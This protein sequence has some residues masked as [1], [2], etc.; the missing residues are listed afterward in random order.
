MLPDRLQ[1]SPLAALALC[2][3]LAVA[4]CGHAPD[5]PLLAAVPATSE[6][7]IGGVH[8]IFIATTRRKADDPRIVFD[9]RRSP[10]RAFAKVTVSVPAERKVGE[11]QRPKGDTADPARFMTA[12][13]L[14]A[15]ADGDTF[16]RSVRDKASADGGRALV[17]VHGYNTAFASAVYRA[18]QIVHDARY[19]GAPVLF[20]WASGGRTTDYVY[21]R[22]STNAARDA[23]ED[24][25]RSLARSGVKR[26]DIVAHSMGTWLAMETLR[27]LAIGGDKDLDGRLG[28]VILASPDI[29]VDVFKTQMKRYGTPKRPF[30]V[31]LSDDDRA[32]RFSGLIAGRQPRLGDYR[33]AQDIASLGVIVV[34]LTRV[35]AADSFNHTKF[36][37][38]PALVQLLGD[39]LREG[40]AFAPELDPLEAPGTI[41]RGVVGAAEIIVTTPFRVINLAIG[42]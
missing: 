33:D 4:G 38:N 18:T 25:L 21:D 6:V 19:T 2:A 9:G 14:T 7:G 15:Y 32:L 10:D 5:R 28:D 16:A 34:D 30:F 12:K 3:A 22:D 27:S 31:L 11:I 36:A 24:V 35:K 39:R 42:G 20:T 13:S 23:L 29:D 17:F 40:D 1:T 26:I 37:D 41:A 8:D